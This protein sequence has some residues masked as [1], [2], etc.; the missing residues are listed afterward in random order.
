[1]LSESDILVGVKLFHRVAEYNVI[2]HF[3]YKRRKGDRSIACGY[4]TRTFL[5]GPLSEQNE[6]LPCRRKFE[7]C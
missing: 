4:V 1:M 5:V 3:A 2:K 6:L 7:I